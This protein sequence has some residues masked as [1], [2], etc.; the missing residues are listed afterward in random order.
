MMGQH[1]G[2]LAAATVY[3]TVVRYSFQA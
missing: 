3:S 2:A 1:S